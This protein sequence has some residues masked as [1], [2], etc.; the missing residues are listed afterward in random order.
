METRAALV[1]LLGLSQSINEK[2]Y[3]KKKITSDRHFCK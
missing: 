1:T 3:G 2:N